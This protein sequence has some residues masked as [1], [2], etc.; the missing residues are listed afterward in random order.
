MGFKKDMGDYELCALYC[1]YY[2][3]LSSP[4]T[5]PRDDHVRAKYEELCKEI[6]GE[7]AERHFP[8]ERRAQ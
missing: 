1:D 6:L 3:W 4:I 7:V 5:G 2:E 8:A